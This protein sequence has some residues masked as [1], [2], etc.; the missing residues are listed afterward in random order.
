M[1][2]IIS[3]K[4]KRNFVVESNNRKSPSYSSENASSASSG[5]P[6]F[7]KAPAF[8][9]LTM[10]DDIE[11]DNFAM[12]NIISNLNE[13]KNK[14]G[15]LE[16]AQYSSQRR[17]EA[18]LE[19]NGETLRSINERVKTL[20]AIIKEQQ[21]L[22]RSLNCVPNVSMSPS[23]DGLL[24]DTI[25]SFNNNQS[26][27]RTNSPVLTPP[28]SRPNSNKSSVSRSSSFRKVFNRLV[29]NVS[30]KTK[31]SPL[32]SGKSPCIITP[33]TSAIN[34][35]EESS[36]V[37]SHNLTSKEFAKALNMAVISTD[38]LDDLASDVNHGKICKCMENHED[39]CHVASNNN[40]NNNIDSLSFIP[41][42]SPTMSKDDSSIANSQHTAYGTL[43]DPTVQSIASAAASGPK[44]DLEIFVPPEQRKN[45]TST[46]RL[47]NSASN[48]DVEQN[49][50]TPTSKIQ[51]GNVFKYLEMQKKALFNKEGPMT[52]PT[53]LDIESLKKSI[54]LNRETQ[55]S[56]GSGSSFVSRSRIDL[57][58]N[59]Y[60]RR[61]HSVSTE[62][63]HSLNK[64][65]GA[66]SLSKGFNGNN[67]LSVPS[68]PKR[69][70]HGRSKSMASVATLKKT[71]MRGRF[72]VTRDIKDEKQNL[73]NKMK[74]ENIPEEQSDNTNEPAYNDISSFKMPPLDSLDNNDKKENNELLS[75]PNAIKSTF[76]SRTDIKRRES[77]MS[78]IHSLSDIVPV[79]QPVCHKKSLS[80]H[81]DDSIKY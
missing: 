15:S 40:S 1:S 79:L 4:P 73:D 51:T 14:Q 36:I 25:V 80:V 56:N 75:A 9:N 62:L 33:D 45:S 71:E 3:T 68:K 8:S 46:L 64:N 39:E 31:S 5:S 47:M 78:D 74:K 65:N 26:S 10:R 58:N 41:I 13:I 50:N 22:L 30:I 7:Y 52:L 18:I 77:P 57:L 34:T 29:R 43:N 37:D 28:Y 72:T 48:S 60:Q 27:L 49:V 76:N 35:P 53:P 42:S 54:N 24:D 21:C 38:T 69:I 6:V 2:T 12:T 17:I 66:S 59:T 20:E 55:S 11:I 32:R 81:I 16:T 67:S 23:M 19:L 61:K 70:S 63:P 44:L